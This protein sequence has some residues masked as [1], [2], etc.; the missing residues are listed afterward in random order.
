M[1]RLYTLVQINSKN[2]AVETF[3]NKHRLDFYDCVSII[4]NRV[5]ITRTKV[6]NHVIAQQFV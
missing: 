6:N 3:W 5:K 4:S 1:Y 2:E